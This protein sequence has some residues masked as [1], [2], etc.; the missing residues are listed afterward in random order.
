MKAAIVSLPLLLAASGIGLILLVGRRRS[1]MAICFAGIGTA[2]ATVSSAVLIESTLVYLGLSST[3]L[4]LEWLHFEWHGGQAS[5]FSL[6]R[7]AI[8]L[9][10]A[11]G[12][13]MRRGNGAP[14]S[15]G[16]DRLKVLHVAL[17]ITAMTA[18]AAA[19]F[20]MEHAAADVA[21]IVSGPSPVSAQKL[22]DM[23]HFVF[24]GAGT[25]W[26][27]GVLLL[28]IALTSWRSSSLEESRSWAAIPAFVA[29]LVLIP[30]FRG[31]THSYHVRVTHSYTEV[32]R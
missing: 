26:I 4:G 25:G 10:V 9:L 6:L 2:A 30:I 15:P 11:S 3:A 31:V 19:F 8:V 20:V 1:R 13:G 22:A 12:A 23:I 21:K 7:G 29:A 5:F 32:V 14:A 17:A 27:S 16:L 18:A 24:V 28:V